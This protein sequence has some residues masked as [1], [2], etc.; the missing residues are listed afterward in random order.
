MDNL[1]AEL[2][3]K[4]NLITL[5]LLGIF[6][7]SIPLT[8]NLI[9]QQQR[10]RSQAAD[11]PPIVYKGSNVKV[12]S[13]LS[14]TDPAYYTTTDPSVQVELRSPLGPQAP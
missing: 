2:L 9:K 13:N 14:S 3:T 1:K 12:N 7:L 10:I 6:A 11:E 4:S 8:V 5:V